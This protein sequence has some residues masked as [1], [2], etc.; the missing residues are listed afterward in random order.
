M[1]EMAR[2]LNRL[3]TE[4][5]IGRLACPDDGSANPVQLKFAIDVEGSELTSAQ[6]RTMMDAAV[7]C[8]RSCTELLAAVA[9]TK[10]PI[11]PLW[12]AFLERTSE[13]EEEEQ[14]EV[15]AEL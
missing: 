8:Y 5:V 3:N 2:I 15:P 13:P 14:V 9:L 7:V 4:L 6:I 12:A 1:V 11:E 10:Q